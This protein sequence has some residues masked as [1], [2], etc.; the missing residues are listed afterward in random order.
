MQGPLVIRAQ[1]PA[2]GRATNKVQTLGVYTNSDGSALRLGTTRDRVYVG[3]N[4]VSINGPVK[5]QEVQEKNA[6]QGIKV[7]NELIL[8]DNQIKELGP[9]TEDTDAVTYCLLYTSDAADE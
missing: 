1:N 2:D 3:N 9:A 7:S 6:S 5:L 8:K 4:D